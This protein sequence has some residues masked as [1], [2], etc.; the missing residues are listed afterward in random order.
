VFVSTTGWVLDDTNLRRRYYTALDGARLERLRAMT[1][2]TH[3]AGRRPGVPA[4]GLTV[5]RGHGDIQTTMIYAHHVRELI[6]RGPEVR[7]LPGPS[8]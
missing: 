5:M 8:Q 2:A 6:I 7:I 1:Y 3:S 4:C